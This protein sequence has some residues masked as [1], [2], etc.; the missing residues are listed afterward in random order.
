VDTYIRS[1]TYAR[2]PTLPYIPGADGAGVVKTVGEG[3]TSVKVL[4]KSIH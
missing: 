3:V 2:K 1:G 4:T